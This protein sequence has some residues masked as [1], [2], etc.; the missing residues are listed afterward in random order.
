MAN[1]RNTLLFASVASEVELVDVVVAD[2]V[3]VVAGATPLAR[4][5]LGRQPLLVRVVVLQQRREVAVFRN[6]IASTKT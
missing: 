4:R 2:R 5:N 1:R 3:L 6:T